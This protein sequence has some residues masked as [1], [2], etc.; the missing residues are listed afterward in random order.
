M[1]VSALAGEWQ[2]D[3]GICFSQD[4]AYL[5]PLRPLK[6]VPVIHLLRLSSGCPEIEG[7]APLGEQDQEKRKHPRLRL[8]LNV[9]FTL[10]EETE[11]PEA[12][13][14]TVDVSAGGVCFETAEWTDLSSG[15]QLDLKIRGFSRYGTSSLFRELRGRGTVVRLDRFR[16]PTGASE[17]GKVAVCFDEPPHFEVYDWTN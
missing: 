10:S 9:V 2:A 1:G 14:I 5:P 16:A 11:R 6:L 15:R 3:R 7:K 4:A 12:A 17:R 8:R 13:G